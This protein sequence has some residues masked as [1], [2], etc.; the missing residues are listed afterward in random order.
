MKVRWSERA[1]A[2]FVETA[3]YVAREFG[4]QAAIKMRNGI[5]EAVASISQFP[6]IGKTSFTD[7]ETCTE[8]REFSCRLSS[9]VYSIY[10]DEIYIVSIWSNRQNRAN[11]Y[12]TLRA[13]AKGM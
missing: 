7:E 5:N 3:A 8:F 9:V 6:N 4:G 10:K 1:A 12:L 2:E 13:D 11:L